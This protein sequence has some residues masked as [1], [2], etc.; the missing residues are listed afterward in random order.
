MV[1]KATHFLIIHKRI[2]ET[3]AQQEGMDRFSTLFFTSFTILC[4]THEASC[5][6][7]LVSPLIRNN[8][9]QSAIEIAASCIM[10]QSLI[11]TSKN[12]VRCGDGDI[13]YWMVSRLNN[14]RRGI[15][16]P[17]CKS[18]ASYFL[19]NPSCKLSGR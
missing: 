10:I 3:K 2:K 1:H 17:Q 12:L 7:K 15:G 14:K 19:K 4:A 8:S 6:A 11:C 5:E 9:S 18:I 16:S 13:P